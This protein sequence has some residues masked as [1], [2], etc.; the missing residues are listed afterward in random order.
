MYA[1]PPKV[2]ADTGLLLACPDLHGIQACFTTQ[3][4][5]DISGNNNKS[6]M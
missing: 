2:D 3:V 1:I 6:G 5:M 4:V